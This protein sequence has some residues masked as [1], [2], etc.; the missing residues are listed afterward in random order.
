[1]TSVT[2]APADVPVRA[3]RPNRF[4]RY[5]AMPTN[6]LTVAHAMIVQIHIHIPKVA[7]MI[8]HI[9]TG[10]APPVTLVIPQV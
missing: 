4:A 3:G 7:H 8:S 9:A 2:V 1:M 5:R 10:I 6:I